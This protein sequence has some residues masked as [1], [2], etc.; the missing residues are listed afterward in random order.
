MQR[1]FCV[2]ICTIGSQQLTQIFNKI[3]K[4]SMHL[5]CQSRQTNAHQ[6]K[7]RIW[8]HCLFCFSVR[9]K[10]I[11]FWLDGW[12]AVLFAL[13]IEFMHNTQC[14]RCVFIIISF[15]YRCHVWI[16]F[17]FNFFPSPSCAHAKAKKKI[18]RGKKQ[19]IMEYN[20]RRICRRLQFLYLFHSLARFSVWR[21][22]NQIY[23]LLFLCI[24]FFFFVIES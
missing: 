19:I 15:V 9:I 12:S 23:L 7:K 16:F 20:E 14:S 10:Y 18:K 13:C 5:Q 17:I 11:T 22:D 24:F 8:K 3:T 1:K 4:P 2:H 21:N 6:K